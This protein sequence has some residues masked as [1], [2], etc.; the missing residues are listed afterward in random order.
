ML[1]LVRKEAA[2]DSCGW[3]LRFQG[4]QNHLRGK[5]GGLVALGFVMTPRGNHRYSRLRPQPRV[6]LP[7]ALQQILGT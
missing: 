4:W 6:W 5:A 7:S 2:R 3:R 1:G